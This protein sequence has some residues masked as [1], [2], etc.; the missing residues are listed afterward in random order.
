MTPDPYLCQV[1]QGVG[2]I[3]ELPLLH[4]NTAQ[5]GG[6]TGRREQEEEVDKGERGG[7]EEKGIR[8]RGEEGRLQEWSAERQVGFMKGQEEGGRRRNNTFYI[9]LALSLMTLKM[10]RIACMHC[11]YLYFI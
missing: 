10:E 11:K 6:G 7:G 4:L 2:L 3:I 5:S 1:H 9:R 8:K